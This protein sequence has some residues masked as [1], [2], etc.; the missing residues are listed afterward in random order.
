[1]DHL[2]GKKLSQKYRFD[3]GAAY[4]RRAIEFDSSYAPA[5]LQLA[6]DLLRL[7]HDEIG[8]ELAR[9]V[10]DD[11]PYNVVAVNLLNLNGKIDS[12]RVLQEEDIHVRMDRA[13]AAIYG[14][15]VLALLKEAKEKSLEDIFLEL[16]GGTQKDQISRFLDDVA[17][18]S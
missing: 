6:Q 9:K 14:D 3:E 13:E 5:R 4:Q 12:F 11:D 10:A 17:N 1:M 8:W 15:A 7:G 2:I 16:T 18:H